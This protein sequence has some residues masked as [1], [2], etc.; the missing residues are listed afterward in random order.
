MQPEDNS[1]ISDKMKSA[2]EGFLNVEPINPASLYAP[3]KTKASATPKKQA[4]KPK[5]KP[6]DVQTA[7]F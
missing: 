6:S 2:A 1:Y 7:L 5:P 3:K 4:P